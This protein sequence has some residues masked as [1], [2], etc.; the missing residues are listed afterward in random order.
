MISIKHFTAC[1]LLLLLTGTAAAQSSHQLLQSCLKIE[2]WLSSLEINKK[3][4][5]I[6]WPNIKDSTTVTA[7]L[8]SGNSGVILFYLELYR[9]TKNS[10]YLLKAKQGMN[11]LFATLPVHW[12]N[13]NI[14]LY[15]GVSG[16]C[17]TAHQ[18]YLQTRD[19]KYL[20]YAQRYLA[21]IEQHLQSDSSL[22][23][24]AND[25][26][27][28]Y[29]GIG[30]TF[31]YAAKHSFFPNALTIAA[32]IGDTLLQKSVAGDTGIRWPMFMK[33]TVRK[34]YYPNFSHGTAGVCYFLVCLY[35]QTKNKKYL[36]AAL[37]GA[38]HLESITNHNGW[39]YHREPLGKDRYY[40][41]WCHGP[42]GTA[43]LYY[44][45]YQLTGNDKWR[46]FI[47]LAAVSVMHCGVPEKTTN[48]F[49]NNISVCCGNAGMADF[50]LQLYQ[51]FHNPEY[52]SF[53]KHLVNNLLKRAHVQGNNM[54]WIQAENRTQ[55]DLLQMQTGL[56]QGAAGVGIMLLQFYF[57]ENNQRAGTR[58]PDNPF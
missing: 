57:Y 18:Y 21:R 46:N 4:S 48:G 35:E 19:K 47:T 43:R 11:Y 1:L 28:G 13:D 25:I 33:D 58:L 10:S 15:T 22:P 14:G 17:Y 53:S 16:I 23:G 5:G 50:Y 56:M 7:D 45:L 44:K 41:S 26:V 30:L 29:A 39:V 12:G 37:L 27:Y 6:A 38:L 52:L 9:A 8:Y 36:D 54:S 31:L 20:Q 3:D 2:R 55:P 32:S 51:R 49:W 24:M 42:A 40:L 34:V